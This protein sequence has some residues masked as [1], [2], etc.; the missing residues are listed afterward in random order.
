MSTRQPIC[1]SRLFRHF[2]NAIKNEMIK[3]TNHLVLSKKTIKGLFEVIQE[4]EAI[5]KNNPE[6]AAKCMRL[7]NTLGSNCHII[8]NVVRL[9]TNQLRE[10]FPFPFAELDDDTSS[11][12]SL[13]IETFSELLNETAIPNVTQLKV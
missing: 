3:L 10:E 9:A 8:F 11:I 6:F 12:S 5:E 4:A 2:L 7:R 1:H 13:P